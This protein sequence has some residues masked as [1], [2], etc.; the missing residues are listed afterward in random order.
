MNMYQIYEQVYHTKFNFYLDKEEYDKLLNYVDY[1]QF[2]ND[3]TFVNNIKF[4][5]LTYN[6]QNVANSY[7]D[8]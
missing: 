1:S 5:I 8:L 6:N 7:I 4:Q 2:A 3:A